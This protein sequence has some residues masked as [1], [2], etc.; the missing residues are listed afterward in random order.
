M[1][2][3]QDP[4]GSIWTR[5]NPLGHIKGVHGAVSLTPVELVPA[6]LLPGGSHKSGCLPSPLQWLFQVVAGGDCNGIT[7]TV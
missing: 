6:L 3:Y 1:G 5:Q 7:A 4:L 2:I